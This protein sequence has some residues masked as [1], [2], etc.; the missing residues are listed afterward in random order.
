M[1]RRQPT[2]DERTALRAWIAIAETG[3][4]EPL[5]EAALNL[6]REVAVMVHRLAMSECKV[7]AKKAAT[8][9]AGA[10]GLTGRAI[11][12]FRAEQSALLTTLCLEFNR[13]QPGGFGKTEFVAEAVAEVSARQVFRRLKRTRKITD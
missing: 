5:P 4:G 2:A 8:Q 13:H 6:L 7:P 10:A 12:D 9:A 11:A 3:P 1:N